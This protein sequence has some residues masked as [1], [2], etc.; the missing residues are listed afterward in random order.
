MKKN[1]WVRTLR[2]H[3]LFDLMYTIE[4]NAKPLILIEPLWGIP[5]NLLAPFTTLYMVAMGVTDVQIG[6]ILSI[7][8]VVQVAFSFMGGII[9]DKL[10]R[11]ITTM[12][13]DFFGWSVACFIWAI[14]QNFWFFLIAV[15]MNSFEQINQTAWYCLLIEDSKEKDILNIFNWITI[16]GLVS[17][18][19]API[20]G[21]LI[22][23]FSL[24]PVIRGVYL[25]FSITMLLKTIIT[26]RYTKETR[27]GAVRRQATKG[28]SVWKL[29]SEYKQLVP[30]IFRNKA[31]VQTLAIMMIVYITGMINGNFFGLYVNLRLG[32]PK[33]YLAFFPILRAI[34]M[35][36]F[37]FAIQH[38]LERLS[39][40]IPMQVGLVMYVLCQLLLI[41]SPANQI[42]PVALF[43][44]M[45]A[46]ANAL[47][48]PRKDAMQA[49]N[50]DPAERARIVALLTA[51][52]I[53]FSS[54]FG[55]VVGLLSSIDR[56]LPFVLSSCL[57]LLAIVV[58]SRFKE[59]KPAMESQISSE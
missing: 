18:F 15:L 36:V 11:R 9:A 4:G 44:L 53:G 32:I 10:G 47:V 22:G 52:M 33:Q 45:E 21:L 43:T 27:Q 8:M 37:M 28:V 51:F 1:K 39:L 34:V 6:L 5:Y 50:V 3:P 25:S 40:K 54:P 29:M 14:S 46:V 38:R 42:L 24:V 2:S 48:M 35:I 16:G 31:T 49:M 59:R 20:S 17:V 26:M 55:Y 23:R 58:I 30:R 41:F 13:G 56:R 7:A 57:Y 19:F 12:L